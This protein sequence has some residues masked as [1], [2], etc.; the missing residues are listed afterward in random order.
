[1]LLISAGLVVVA[2]LMLIFGFVGDAPN[3]IFVSLGTSTVSAVFLVMAAWLRRNEFFPVASPA[4]ELSLEKQ[5]SVLAESLSRDARKLSE[6]ES[7]ILARAAMAERLRVE[8]EQNN[9]HA[10]ESREYAK[11]QQR[12]ADAVDE[13]LKL[14]TSN[15]VSYFMRGQRKGQITYLLLGAILGGVIG[16]GLQELVDIIQG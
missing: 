12:A 2:I 4:S 11:A 6:L 5:L 1:M 14:Q 10:I 13:L 3:L 16:V 8:A 7:A 15:L 9:K